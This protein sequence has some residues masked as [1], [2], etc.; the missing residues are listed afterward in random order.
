M[1]VPQ[2][3]VIIRQSTLGNADACLRRMQYDI[4]T[5]PGEYHT[6]SKRAIGTAYHA[7][8][9]LYYRRRKA[10]EDKPNALYDFV[11]AGIE[12]FDDE[13]EHAGEFFL[14]DAEDFPDR[15]SCV[16][17]IGRCITNYFEG[18]FY[19]PPEF[20]VVDIEIP[21]E[22][23]AGPHTLK[24]GGI[25][26]V[27]R[28]PVGYIIGDD[29]KTAGK[30][31]DQY[32]HTPRKN[33]QASL[34]THALKALYPDAI[35]YRFV[36][37]VMTYRGVFARRISDPRPDHINAVL[38]KVGQVASLYEGM[39]ANGLELPANPSSNLCSPKYCDFWDVCPHGRALD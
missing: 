2:P 24:S 31:W 12:A 33:N 16:E 39:R 13:A 1:E 32:K 8:L 23:P 18:E 6:G 37:S 26:L 34:Y 30:M 10:G 21:F 20:E 36:F 4:E 19:W 14:W 35:G 38:A 25:D 27:L 7:G 15:D 11:K 3:G 17:V 5:P 29:H 9:E 22:L 28:D